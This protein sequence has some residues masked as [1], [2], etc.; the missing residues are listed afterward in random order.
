LD[1][2]KS[3][4]GGSSPAAITVGKDAFHDRTASRLANHSGCDA[5]HASTIGCSVV[6]NSSSSQ[7]NND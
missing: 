3:G 7:R 4:Y 6:V 2:K 1:W 5:H